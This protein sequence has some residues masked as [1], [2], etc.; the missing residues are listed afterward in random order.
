MNFTDFKRSKFLIIAGTIAILA[1][2]SFYLRMW[3]G[4]SGNPDV[5]SSVGMDDPMYNLRMVEQMVANFPVYNWFDPMTYY[6]AGQPRHWG[7]LFTLISAFG[8]Y[9][10]G[11][12]TKTDIASVCLFIPGY[13]AAVM[14]P[15]VYVIVRKISD[16]ISGII[17]ALFIAII[18][19]Q[20]FFRSYYGYFDHHIGEVLFSTLFCMVYIIAIL[21]CREKPVQIFDSQ[22]WKKPMILGIVCGVI[23]VLGLAIMP[24]QILFA[25]IVAI[26]TPVWFMIQRNTG[27]IGAS[28]LVINTATF[29]V[30]IFG[31]F[32]IGSDLTQ[33]GMN[34]YTLG[35]PIAYCLIIIGTWI[36]FGF[37]YYLKDKGLL[38][39]ILALS[40]VTI[41][42]IILLAVFIPSLFNYFI[43]NAVM[44]FGDDIHWQT[45]QEA[46]SWTI[47]DAWHSFNYALIL[48]VGGYLVLFN[49]FRKNLN[50]SYLLIIIWSSL[51]FYA[52]IKH[53]RYEYFFAVPLAIMAAI[54]VGSAINVVITK[55]SVY[56]KTEPQQI[57]S[58]SRTVKAKKTKIPEPTHLISSY[59]LISSILVFILVIACVLLFINNA[60]TTDFSIGVF[61]LNEDWRESC[62][63]L[64]QNTPDTGL[65]FLRN[66]DKDSYELPPESYG[67]MSWWDYG[68]IILEIGNRP[69]NANP[70][71]F[72]VDGDYGAARFFITTKEDVATN[73]LDKLQTKYVMTDSEMDTGKFVPMAI[74]NNTETGGTPFM[75]TYIIPNPDNPNTGDQ[76]PFF[77]KPYYETIVS[78]LHNFDGS[79]K[80]P[81]K[82]YFIQYMKPNGTLTA[83]L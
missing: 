79:M 63:W 2:T 53:I 14:V 55:Y 76:V 56:K 23:Y 36:L 7:P 45:I 9:L 73:I 42:G 46:R 72:G 16:E 60:L 8:C 43:G 15:V 51:I 47:T 74:W 30:S 80:E 57:S 6:P 77:Q 40:G 61:K 50:P 82:V 26:F 11:A 3:P 62:T 58:Y 25:L 5:I 28:V 65:N 31:F 19:G 10:T 38:H 64:A 35:H 67:I 41:L 1:I 49:R 81:D 68:H 20:Y 4:L 21:Y 34:F 32:L 78:R 71:Q 37:S 66:Y 24:T 75:Q 48:F 69:P 70:F 13:M 54:T 83:P 18:P 17:A 33:S 39:Y 44:F 22:T 52:T 59:K 12:V 27:H 29:L